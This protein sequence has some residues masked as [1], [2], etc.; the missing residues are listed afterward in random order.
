MA[1]A[2]TNTTTLND[3]QVNALIEE[4]VATAARDSVIAA[5]RFTVKNLDPDSGAM[6]HTFT[7]FQEFVA[8]ALTEETGQDSVAATT[9]GVTI[10]ATGVGVTVKIT[11]QARIGGIRTLSEQVLRE[12]GAAIA[13]KMDVD[14]LALAAGLSGGVGTTGTDLSLVT[15]IAAKQALGAGKPLYGYFGDVPQGGPVVGALAGPMLFIDHVGKGD[16][17]R[18][19]VT[20]GASFLS[21]PAAAQVLQSDGTAPNGFVGSLFGVPVFVSDNVHTASTDRIG[22]LATPS[23]IGVVVKQLADLQTDYDVQKRL[24]LLASDAFYGVGEYLDRCGVKLTYG[25]S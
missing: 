2:F 5:N 25:A 13:K 24:N 21:D 11:K 18:D 7:S 8:S 3:L 15:I 10:T 9:D 17:D 4:Y 22:A 19:M 14:T 1:D 23:A 20:S 6:S 16:L 12:M